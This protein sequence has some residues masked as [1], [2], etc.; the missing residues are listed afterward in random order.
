M[1]ATSSPFNWK[2]AD[3]EFDTL[4]QELKQARKRR[5]YYREQFEACD[6]LVTDLAA[7]VVEL[8]GE[9]DGAH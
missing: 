3:P 7:K 9:G 2:E 6:K 8:I 4:M 5:Q 1:T